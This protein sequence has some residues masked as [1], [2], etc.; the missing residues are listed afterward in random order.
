VGQLAAGPVIVHTVHGFLFNENTRGLR[1]ALALGAEKW[2]AAWS[3][4]LLFQSREDYTWARER[5]LKRAEGLHLI[6]NGIDEERFDPLEYPGARLAKRRELGFEPDDLVVGMVGRLVREKGYPE[7]F[8]MATRMAAVHPG[9]RFLVVGISEPD[10]SDAL[11][12]AALID[13]HGLR[14]KC[15][16]LDQR[17]DMPELYLTMDVAVLPSHREGIPRALMEASAMSR[18]VVATDIRGCREVVA[19]A[20]TGF[21]FPVRDVDRFA[22]AVGRLLGDQVAREQMGKAGRRR[23]LEGFTESATAARVADCYEQMLRSRRPSPA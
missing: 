22:D 17:Q 5:R 14:G 1:R 18:P 10:Q 9:A 19:E 3:D 21:L 4:H 2:T 12:A 15:V 8:E 13:L 11:D 6:G 16:V 23:M 7:F 20:E